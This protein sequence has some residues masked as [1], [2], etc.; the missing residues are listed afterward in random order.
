MER[1]F[2]HWRAKTDGCG[3]SRVLL[4]MIRMAGVATA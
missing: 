1:F 3:A 4:D 2:I